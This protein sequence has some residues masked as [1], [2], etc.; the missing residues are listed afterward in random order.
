[1]LRMTADLRELERLFDRQA[2]FSKVRAYEVAAEEAIGAIRSNTARGADYRGNAFTPYKDA[3]H[4]AKREAK[5]LQ[6][7]FPDLFFT[8]DMLEGLHYDR[9]MVTVRDEAQP[10]AEGLNLKR[11]FM[12]VSDET[13][14][15]IADR[16]AREI[17]NIRG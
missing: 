14:R 15:Q 4:M 17:E 8:G 10:R 9:K 6:T 11:E 7:A 1:M 3:R 13:A 12:N 5:G 2:S 16:E